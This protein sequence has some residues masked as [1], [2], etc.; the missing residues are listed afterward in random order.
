MNTGTVTFNVYA[1]KSLMVFLSEF[2][3]TTDHENFWRLFCIMFD[4]VA[5][6]LRKLFKKKFCTRY[7]RPWRDNQ[8]SGQYFINQSKFNKPADLQ[9]ITVIEN[10]N[11]KSFDLTVLFA[12]LLSSGTGIMQPIRKEE[13]YPY[14]ES[15]RINALRCIR[16]DVLT[17]AK[18]TTLSSRLFED[19]IKLLDDIY[20]QLRWD[21]TEML[22]LSQEPLVTEDYKRLQKLLDDEMKKFSVLAGK[23]IF[24]D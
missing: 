21:T 7:S 9:I 24:R 1:F 6:N 10:G 20:K 18:S 5:I 23:D 22:R 11:T 3:M 13:K 14:R 12:C 17:H 8:T 2:K 15:E 16:N 4:D 19:K